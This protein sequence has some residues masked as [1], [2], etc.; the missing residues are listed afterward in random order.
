MYWRYEKAVKVKRVAEKPKRL[1]SPFTERFGSAEDKEGQKRMKFAKRNEV[2]IPTFN[3]K[4]DM[5][6]ESTV[7]KDKQSKSTTYASTIEPLTVE[8]LTWMPPPKK[9]D[10]QEN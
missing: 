3:L 2:E 7:K 5:V 1:K 9:S 6:H 4:I 10:Q 8:P